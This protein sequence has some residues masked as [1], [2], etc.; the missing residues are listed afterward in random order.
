VPLMVP[1]PAALHCAALQICCILLRCS[2][3]AAD[4]CIVLQFD[5]VRCAL[6]QGAALCCIVLQNSTNLLPIVQMY[7]KPGQKHDPFKP[8]PCESL[9]L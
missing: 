1:H 7:Y 4:R 9:P 2:R 5:A 6:P 8:T 3:C